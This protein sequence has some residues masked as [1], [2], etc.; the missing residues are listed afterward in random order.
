MAEQQEGQKNTKKKW[1]T[2]IGQFRG[3]NATGAFRFKNS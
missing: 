1:I 3:T 2:P